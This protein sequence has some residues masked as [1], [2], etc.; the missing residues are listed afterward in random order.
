[1]IDSENLPNFK[2]KIKEE[3]QI[4]PHLSINLE[5][6]IIA[7]KDKIINHLS[8]FPSGNFVTV[9][10]DINI[11]IWSYNYKLIQEIKIYNPTNKKEKITVIGNDQTLDISYTQSF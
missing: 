8:F 6:G 5:K 2:I 4:I 1:M 10:N 11:K 3:E 7:H 9:A